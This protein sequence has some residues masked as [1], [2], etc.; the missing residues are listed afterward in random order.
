ML[1]GKLNKSS[2]IFYQ[3]I[4]S[5]IQIIGTIAQIVFFYPNYLHLIQCNSSRR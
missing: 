4:S 1:L 2:Q 3:I 5:F